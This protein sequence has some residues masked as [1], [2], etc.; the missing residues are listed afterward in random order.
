VISRR[1]LAWWAGLLAALGGCTI[2]TGRLLSCDGG[3]SIAALAV[4]PNT[5]VHL[6]SVQITPAG[7]LRA[8]QTIAVTAKCDQYSSDCAVKFTAQAIVEG[9][10]SRAMPPPQDMP[11]PIEL[12]LRDD[13]QGIDPSACDGIWSGE[14]KVA[15]R[16]D[17]VLR[18]CVRL[19]FP[20]LS[21]PAS[22]NTQVIQVPDIEVKAAKAKS[23]SSPRQNRH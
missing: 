15:G 16:T 1:V 13:G 9:G 4:P 3:K 6:Q 17:F 7:A 22:N 8:G 12:E 11:L 5:N 20:A 23:P 19:S 10:A 2:A 18:A 21:S 14:C